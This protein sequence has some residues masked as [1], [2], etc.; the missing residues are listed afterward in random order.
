MT[1]ETVTPAGSATYLNVSRNGVNYAFNPAKVSFVTMNGLSGDDFLSVGSTVAARA[2]LNGDGGNDVLVGGAESDSLVGGSGNDRFV[3]DADTS[4]GTDRVTDSSGIDTLDFSSTTSGAITLNLGLTTTQVV[5]ANLSLRLSTGNS[6]DNIIGG[7]LSDTLTGNTLA[8][9]LTGGAGND[10][11]LFDVDLV[12]GADTINESG[13]GIDTLDFSATT[14]RAVSVNLGIATLQTVAAGFLTLNLSANNTIENVIGGSLAD[15]LTGNSLA[16]L[17]AGGPGNDFYG[18][19]TDSFLGSDTVNDVS[20]IDTILFSAT[21]T[22]A[23]AIDLSTP[24]AQVVTAINLT[25]TLSSG[26]AIENVIGGSL[27]DTLTGNTLDNTITGG[28][29][30]DT[31]L[32][33]AGNDNYLF[34]TDLALGSDTIND[35]SGVDTLDFSAT[36]TLGVT[37]N[38]ASAALQVMNTGLSLTLASANSVENIIGGSL[39]DTLTGNSLANTLTGGPGNDTMTGGAGDDCYKFA[40]NAVSIGTDTINEA[41]GGVD[42]LDFSG[43]TALAITVNL[44]TAAAQVVNASLTLTLS[45]GN[46]MENVIGGSLADTLT[47]NALANTL[48]GGGGNDTLTGS[49]GDDTYLFNTDLALGSDT[50]NEAGGGIDTLDFSSTL[51]SAVVVNLGDAAAQTVTAGRLTLILSAGNTMENVMGGA[52]GDTLTG[53]TLANRLTGGAGNDSLTGAA[54][55]DTYVFD[56]DENLGAVIVNESGGG[57]DWLSFSGTSTRAISVDLSNPAVQQVSDQLS[58]QLLSATS[59]E[60]V[61]GGS[62]NDTLTGNALANTLVGLA[63]NDLLT[64]GTGDDTYTFDTDSALGSDTIVEAG[65]IDRLDFSSTTTL[66]V[67]VN[68]SLTTPQVVNAGLTLTLSANNTIENVTGGSQSDI[69]IGN[70]LANTLTGNDGDD[71]LSGRAGNDVLNGG[72]GKNILIG[73]NGADQLNGGTSEDLLIG[74]RYVDENDTTALTALRAEWTSSS[75]FNDRTGHLLGT[76]AGGLHEG[77][78]LTRST[79]KEDSS[80][81]SLVGGSGRDWYLRNSLGTPTVFRDIITDADLDSLFTEIDTWF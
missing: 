38:L 52:S 40:A 42:T 49:A 56:A 57:L 8:N 43:T 3:F 36:T 32:G 61:M 18:F 69:L 47:G 75:S 68:L 51:G 34:D 22:R 44:S 78:S 63:G 23:I 28:P 81:D 66:A 60:N 1:V 17:L 13:G 37:A 73:G 71:V 12:Q 62:L 70:S 7:A 54:G 24:A 53:N 19:D 58:L 59:L 10:R 20:G 30:N 79:V 26:F 74:A 15:G 31:L 45:A 46:T 48:T 21:T 16:N 6:I 65:G 2:T 27:G 14:T 50:I 64:G 80:A 39:G 4:L 5:N 72:N 11:Y 25:L 33:A 76:L 9:T 67:V 77:F 29:G 55:N 35:A 41:G